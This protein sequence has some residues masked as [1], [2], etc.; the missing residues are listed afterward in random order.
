MYRV[1]FLDVEFEIDGS[2]FGGC[3]AELGWFGERVS[4]AY[5]PVGVVVILR[6]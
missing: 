5:L 2:W 6:R 1:F 3:D 4:R